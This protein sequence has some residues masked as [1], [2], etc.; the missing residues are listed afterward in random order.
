MNG[1]S[2]TDLSY[3]RRRAAEERALCDRAANAAAAE[4]H[5]ALAAMHAAQAEQLEGPAEPPAT[6]A[7][8]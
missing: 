6:A 3:H 1:G 4:S 8:A 2:K 7:H 5:R